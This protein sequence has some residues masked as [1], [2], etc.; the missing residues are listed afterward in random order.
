MY[1]I[2]FL[3]DNV[4]K[5]NNT[6]YQ[7]YTVGNLPNSFGFKTKYLGQDEDGNHQYKNGKSHWLKLKGLTYVEKTILPWQQTKHDINKIIK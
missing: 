1:S 2:K 7:G 3:K 5:I 4:I 6:Y